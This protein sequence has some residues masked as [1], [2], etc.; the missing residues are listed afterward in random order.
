M[1][2]NYMA[3]TLYYKCRKCNAVWKSNNSDDFKSAVLDKCPECG[4]VEVTVEH[5][6]VIVTKRVSGLL[7]P[8]RK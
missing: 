4:S 1:Y 2:N 6:D 5:K 7:T 3:L 8:N